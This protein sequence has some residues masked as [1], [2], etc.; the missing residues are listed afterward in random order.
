MK[1]TDNGA[2]WTDISAGLPNSGYEA[3]I[4]D[5][6]NLYTA[7]SAPYG[8]DYPQAH[9]PWYT[10]PPTG[11]TWAGYNNQQPCDSSN[12]VCN[13]PVMMARDSTTNIIY[14]VNWLG[15]VWKLAAPPP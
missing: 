14:S 15:G 4:S 2:S 6:A 11:S 7:P 13:G 1:S 9:G 3:I 5:G 12:N 10:L 8:G